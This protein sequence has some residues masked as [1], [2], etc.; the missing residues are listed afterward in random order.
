ML[1]KAKNMPHNKYAPN[2]NKYS[3]KYVLKE[4]FLEVYLQ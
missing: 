1:E 3:P 4:W 2:L